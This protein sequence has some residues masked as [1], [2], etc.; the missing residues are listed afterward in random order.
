M[1]PSD[2]GRG[3]F[4]PW[5]SCLGPAVLWSLLLQ[6][7]KGATSVVPLAISL[8]TFPSFPSP[9]QTCLTRPSQA[10]L[11]STV[12]RRCGNSSSSGR[13]SSSSMTGTTRVPSATQSCSKVRPVQGT[14]G[15]EELGLFSLVPETE[16]MSPHMF[17][18]TT[19]CRLSA[20]PLLETSLCGSSLQFLAYRMKRAL[21]RVSERR[22]LLPPLPEGC[23]LFIS[24]THST[25]KIVVES[26]LVVHICSLSDSG[27]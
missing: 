6:P 11:M 7:G 15:R 25:L 3:F 23:F 19:E 4:S 8:D 24:G 20:G 14:M 10:A 2:Q 9:S 12:S 27:G 18:R 21:H 17:T 26:G 13:T 5:C 1:G 22:V 16:H